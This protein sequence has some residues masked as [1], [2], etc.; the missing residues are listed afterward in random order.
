MIDAKKPSPVLLQSLDM[1]LHQ[2]QAL[3]VILFRTRPIGLLDQRRRLLHHSIQYAI[4]GTPQ[5]RIQP[6]FVHRLSACWGAPTRVQRSSA[7]RG[8]L[9]VTAQPSEPSA[10]EALFL[11]WRGRRFEMALLPPRAMGVT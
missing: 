8:P 6:E 2:S 9:L 5:V 11:H 10:F 7:F 3:G 4:Y 1:L